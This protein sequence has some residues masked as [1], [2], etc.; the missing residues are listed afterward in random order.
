MICLSFSAFPSASGRKAPKAAV[1]DVVTRIVNIIFPGAFNTS[2]TTFDA[3]VTSIALANTVD[4]IF[5][6]LYNYR[7]NLVKGALPI[8]CSVLSLTTAQ[9]FKFPTVTCDKFIYDKTGSPSFTIKLRNNSSGINTGYTTASGAF[10]QD[11]LYTYGFFPSLQTAPFLS[12]PD[13]TKVAA[14]R[15]NWCWSLT[16]QRQYDIFYIIAH[17]CV[18]LVPAQTL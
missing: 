8:V 6:D 1:L 15:A 17:H 5:S 13:T 7:V 14:G 11:K 18:A 4:A 2:A 16:C 3:L 9:E 10:V 12:L